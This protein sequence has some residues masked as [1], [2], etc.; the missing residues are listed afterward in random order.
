MKSILDYSIYLVTD[1]HYL[2]GR[3]FYECIEEALKGGVTLVQLREKDVSKEMYLERAIAVKKIC[4][5]YNVPLIINDNIEVAK[6]S[7]AAGVHLGQEDADLVTARRR[8]G[9]DA[10]IGISANTL[11]TAQ[12][13]AEGG[14]DYLGVGAIYPTGSKADAQEV[15]LK[16]LRA[17]RRAVTIPIVG[18]GG[19]TAERCGDVLAAG[20]DGC[21]IISGILAADDIQGRVR[22]IKNRFTK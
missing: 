2:G 18:I 19:I 17:I 12:E 4:D 1:W 21:A 14:A 16:T 6:N 11:K 9:L 10:I 20:A 3:D 5:I 15:G 13:A 8:L 22:D 7:G